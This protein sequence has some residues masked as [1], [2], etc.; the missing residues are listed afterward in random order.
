[1]ITASIV[2]YNTNKIQ[3]KRVI[4]S[5]SPSHNRRLFLIDNGQNCNQYKSLLDGEYI[6]YICNSK[7]VGYGSGHNIGIKASILMKSDYHIILN[8]DLYFNPHIIDELV[9]YADKHKDVVY[10]LPRVT[11]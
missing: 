2:L 3:L 4:E 5:Y 7:N 8:P 9:E 6:S 11:S 10:I 1:M